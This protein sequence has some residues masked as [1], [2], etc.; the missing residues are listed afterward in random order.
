MLAMV[1][2][3][4]E[5]LVLIPLMVFPS[6]ISELLW[7]NHSLSGEMGLWELCGTSRVCSHS[8]RCF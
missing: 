5:I 7:D 3:N 4:K 1:S 8:C 6:S 2:S